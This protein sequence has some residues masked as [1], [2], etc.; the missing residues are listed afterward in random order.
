MVDAF[1]TNPSQT[2][3]KQIDCL[4]ISNI[5]DIDFYFDIERSIKWVLDNGF[6]RIALQFPDEHLNNSIKISSKLKKSLPESTFF[7]LADTSYG[8]CCVDTVAAEHYNADAIIHYGHSCLS[9]VENIPTLLVFDKS[10]LDINTIF[11]QVE[12]IGHKLIILYDVSYHYLYEKIHYKF[13]ENSDVFVSKL[14]LPGENG[15]DLKIHFSR[16][17]PLDLKNSSDSYS[18][19][20]I[21]NKTALKNCFLFYFNKN[22]FYQYNC[23]KCEEVMFNQTNRELMKRY[24]LI[25][26]A[27][28]SSIFGILIGT[29]S[30]AKYKDAINHVAKILQKAQRRYYSFLIGKLNCPKLNNFME[31]D[32]YVLVACNENSLIDSKELNKPIINVYELEMAFNCA[33]LWG[34]EYVVDYQQLL[35]NSLHY[36]SLKLSDQEADVSLVTGGSR[37]VK[38]EESA[39]AKETTVVNRDRA[40][41]VST[42]AAKDILKNRSWTGLEQK[43]GQTEV[44]KAI[45]GTKGIAAEYE[46]EPIK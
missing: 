40:W 6:K 16:Q 28:D 3:E 38:K 32:T 21:G 25:E 4:S 23:G 14:I 9:Q 34:D 1:S 30:V 19:F 2:I 18:F 43:L 31:V 20:Y 44:E 12:K 27:K 13:K 7:I 17:L 5:D 24:Y 11:T 15:Q 22:R 35:E 41:T 8:S 37:L 29:M 10:P 46:S 45:E 33:R 39:D 42:L 36:I 26:K